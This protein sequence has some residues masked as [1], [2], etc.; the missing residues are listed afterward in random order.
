MDGSIISALLSELL[1]Q[2]NILA[3][4]QDLEVTAAISYSIL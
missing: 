1:K 3:A 2:F 4:P